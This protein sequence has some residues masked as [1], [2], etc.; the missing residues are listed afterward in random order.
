MVLVAQ[1]RFSIGLVDKFSLSLGAAKNM[2]PCVHVVHFDALRTVFCVLDA[3]AHCFLC[4]L[5]SIK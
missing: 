3:L 1:V 4:A 5:T 2:R